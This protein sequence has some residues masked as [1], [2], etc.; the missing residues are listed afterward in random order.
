MIEPLIRSLILLLALLGHFGWWVFAYNR[1]NATGLPRNWVKFFEK[2]LC[3]PLTLLIPLVISFND[4][5]GLLRW[6]QTGQWP[7]SLSSFAFCYLIFSVAVVLCIGPL[8]LASRLYLIPPKQLKQ[9]SLIQRLDLRHRRKEL[10]SGAITNGL[11]ILPGNDILSIE[12]HRKSLVLSNW[13]SY[14]DGFRIGHISD[15]HF[16]GHLHPDFYRIAFAELQSLRPDCIALTGDIID[17]QK[18]LPWITDLLGNL[19]AKHGK[20][21]VLGNHDKRLPNTEA[22]RERLRDGGWTDLG[23]R[24][25]PT[26]IHGLPI[27]LAGHELPWFGSEPSISPYKTDPGY[28][29][30]NQSDSFRLALAHSPDAF[31]WAQR[32][33]IHLLLAGHTHGGQV[34]LPGIGPIV[35]PSWYGSKFASGVFYRKPTLMHVSR[36]LAGIHPLRF[37]CAP[38]IAILELQSSHSSP[39]GNFAESRE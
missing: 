12:C 28:S 27:L 8:W 32:E 5:S 31:D 35:A 19:E 26:N 4:G 38:E 22:I 13:P 7:D 23:S 1:I 25:V 2:V 30:E 10:C 14:L 21:F 33:G 37:R 6:V 3:V 16:T 18:C 17:K 11:A 24:V 15:L 36:G 34:R 29:S 39:S 20:F 9:S